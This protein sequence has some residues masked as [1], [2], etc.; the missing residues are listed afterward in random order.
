M[1]YE[2]KVSTA[3]SIVGMRAED[4]VPPCLHSLRWP[5][6]MSGLLTTGPRRLCGPERGDDFPARKL[7]IDTNTPRTSVSA[8]KDE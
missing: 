1:L 3:E 4:G 8:L 5:R 6:L 2:M 7:S